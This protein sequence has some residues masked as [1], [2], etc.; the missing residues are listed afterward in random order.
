LFS[1]ITIN[2]TPI[3]EAVKKPKDFIKRVL[4]AL[5]KGNYSDDFGREERT[6]KSSRRITLNT[7]EAVS[8]C[9]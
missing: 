9:V 2:E 6:K 8:G 1:I 4:P 7:E 3:T 5:S